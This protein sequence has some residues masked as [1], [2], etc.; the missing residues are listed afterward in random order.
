LAA[1]AAERDHLRSLD[2]TCAGIATQ[3]S[4]DLAASTAMRDELRAHRRRGD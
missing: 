2:A 1:V 4:S 3:S